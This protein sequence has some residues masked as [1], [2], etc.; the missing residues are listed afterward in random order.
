M[1]TDFFGALLQELS[2]ILQVP[3]LHPDANNSCLIKFKGGMMAQIE[4][5]RSSQYVVIGIDLGAVPTGRYRENLFLE[6]LRANGMPHPR[7]G[8]F[9]YSKNADHLVLFDMLHV[10][11]LNATKMAEALQPLLVKAQVWKEAIAKGDIPAIE[12][13]QST[14]TSGGLFGLRP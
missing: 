1:V 6:A 10:K 9:G 12:I 3:G 2:Q 14:R 8:T 13:S 4:L 5:D 7:H 11:E